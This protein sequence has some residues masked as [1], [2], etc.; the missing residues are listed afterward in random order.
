[1]AL[2]KRIQLSFKGTT[3]DMKLYMAVISEE[4]QSEFIKKAIEFYLK[5]KEKL[6]DIN[7]Q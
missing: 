6:E 5:Y 2:G 1:M 4:E 3:R 7:K